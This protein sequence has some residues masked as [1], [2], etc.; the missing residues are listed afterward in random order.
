V[1]PRERAVAVARALGLEPDVAAPGRFDGDIAVIEAAIKDAR[2]AALEEAAKEC[3]EV[4][5]ET[6]NTHSAI[7]A[8][9]CAE[10]I[11]KL[12]GEEAAR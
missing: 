3:D 8:R 4:F 12:A 5:V 9:V 7:G 1:T 2:R 6:P 10:R 11:R